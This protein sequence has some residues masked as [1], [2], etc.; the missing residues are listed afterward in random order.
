M[1][2]SFVVL[3]AGKGKRMKSEQP[4]V[5]HPILGRP[6]LSFVLDAVKKTSPERMVV[7][8]GFGSEEVK[9]KTQSDRIEYVL[10]SEQLGTGHAVMCAEEA[11]RSFRGTV[12]IVNGDF[13]LIRPETLSSF[14][15]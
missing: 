12:V 15:G 2:Y 13:P 4:K 9:E 6:M 8:V 10:Q 5:L 14:I 1:S 7:V 3:A 11:L